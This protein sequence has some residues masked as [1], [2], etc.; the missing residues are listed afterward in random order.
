VTGISP[1]KHSPPRPSTSNGHIGFATP[2]VIPP[3]PSLT[4][5]PQHQDLTP[6]VKVTEP[7]RPYP[8]VGP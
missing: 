1:T 5:S 6:P 4:P 3:K 2:S 8:T 7:E